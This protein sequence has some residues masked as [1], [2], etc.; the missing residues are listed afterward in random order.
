M[1]RGAHIGLVFY[2][3][4]GCAE[5]GIPVGRVDAPVDQ[6]GFELPPRPDLPPSCREG[7]SIACA[8]TCGTAGLQTCTLGTFGPCMPPLELCN[9]L[10]EDCDTRI[11]EMVSPRACSGTCRSG[12][13]SCTAGAWGGCTVVTP[14]TETCNNLDDDCDSRIDESLARACMTMCGSGMETCAT[15]TWM[16]CTARLPSMETCDGIDNNCNAMIDDG[17]P[18]R[19]CMTA[20]GTGT[21]MCSTGMWRNCSARQPTMEACN[22]MDDD[23]DSTVDEELGVA[24]VPTTYAALA[25]FEPSCNGSTQRIGAECNIAIHRFCVAQ[26][27]FTTGFG[28]V[29]PAGTNATVACV[30]ATVRNIDYGR[31]DDEQAMCDGVAQ[32]VGDHCNS[33]VHRYCIASMFESGFGPVE[34]IGFS[35]PVGCVSSPWAEDRDTTYSVLATHVA[36]CDGVREDMGLNCNN[37]IHRY[38]VAAGFT[39][40]FGP[41]EHFG[42]NATV[43]CLRTF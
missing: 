39:T 9:N 10:D 35:A 16:G 8:T 4:M 6:P 38:C 7:E 40:G 17:L 12:T 19:P 22:L 43:T 28:P 1:R 15:G 32:R 2:C 25:A 20:C 13:E 5:G 41:V 11:D 24:L 23:C 27:C 30:S 29:I 36:I 26:G 21:E 14:G 34:P 37:A 3:V 33:A 18:P 42:D 31:L